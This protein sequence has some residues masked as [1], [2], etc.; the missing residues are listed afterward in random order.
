[1][2]SIA[3]QKILFRTAMCVMACD[4]EIHDSEVREMKLAFEQTNFFRELVFKDEMKMLISEF[5]RDKKQ[6]MKECFDQIASVDLNPVQQLHVLEIVLRI[7]YADEREDENEMKF[8]KIV[9]SLLG[10]PDEI[11][12]RRFGKVSCL[13]G[14]HSTDKLIP[15]TNDFLNDIVLPEIQEITKMLD[16]VVAE[17]NSDV[18]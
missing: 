3:Y 2:E 15:T 18:G 4:G 17:D 10:V 9:K 12:Y 5:E 7:I 8:L 6:V 14:E 11:F 1:M 13:G 16:N